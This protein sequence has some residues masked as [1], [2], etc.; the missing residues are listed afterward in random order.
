[1]TLDGLTAFLTREVLVKELVE[2]RNL[3]F[4]SN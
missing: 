2:V 1:M 3:I 4:T